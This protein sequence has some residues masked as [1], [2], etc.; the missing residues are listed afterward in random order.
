VQALKESNDVPLT[1]VGGKTSEPPAK[2]SKRILV[3]EDNLTNRLVVEAML[4][5]LGLAY[6]T[7]EN[8][9]EAVQRVT[10]G[11]PPDLILMDCQMPVLDGYEATKQIRQWEQQQGKPRLPIIALTAGAYE[12]DRQDCL[13]AG[14]DDFL[15]K[16]IDLN[17]L[18]ALLKRWA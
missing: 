3:V 6:E 4:G 7:V 15:A 8:G 10:T 1:R 16:P 13:A 9:L 2:S 12:E 11:I 14:M 17:Q 5:K 18:T